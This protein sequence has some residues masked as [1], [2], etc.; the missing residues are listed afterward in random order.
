MP[1]R[2]DT[3]EKADGIV[4]AFQGLL[5]AAALM[6]LVARLAA[7]TR[8]ARVLLKVGTEVEPTCLGSLRR[9]GASSVSA[10]S[11][12]LARWLTEDPS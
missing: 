11:P 9:L 3:V 12:F 1:Y 2:I 7:V 8:P 4:I 6:D 5:D 10:E